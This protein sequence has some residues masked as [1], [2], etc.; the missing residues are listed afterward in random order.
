MIA[1][2]IHVC[3]AQDFFSNEIVSGPVQLNRLKQTTQFQFSS[4]FYSFYFQYLSRNCVTQ[5]AKNLQNT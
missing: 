2:K 3:T 4:I 1:T 5:M